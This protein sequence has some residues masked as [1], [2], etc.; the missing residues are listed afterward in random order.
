MPTGGSGIIQIIGGKPT[1]LLVKYPNA[2]T[3]DF[4]VHEYWWSQLSSGAWSTPTKIADAGTA[5]DSSARQDWLYASVGN[6]YSAGA[7][8]DPN[9]ATAVYV[10]RVNNGS[11]GGSATDARLEKWT[12]GDGGA[13]WSKSL[14]ISGAS[15]NNL[16]IRPRAVT[17]N[18]STQILSPRVTTYTSYTSWATANLWAYNAL[19]TFTVKTSTP[20]WVAVNAPPGVNAYFLLTETSVGSGATIADRT[21]TYNGV[22]VG[23]GL[24]AASGTYG[25][26]LTGFGPATPDDLHH[27]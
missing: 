5:W 13:T 2:G 11:H 4:T 14:D 20:S 18:T 26:Q 24:S 10:S 3:S 21:G 19:A 22:V 15:A 12:T 8:L 1:A 16:N 9:D 23:S 27:V 7:C 25:N 6:T 17:G